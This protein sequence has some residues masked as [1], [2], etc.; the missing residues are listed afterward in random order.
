MRTQ[1]RALERVGSF[2][3]LGF[4]F[5]RREVDLPGL[6]LALHG[7]QLLHYVFLRELTGLQMA[8]ALFARV[9]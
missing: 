1:L 7:R 4:A 2:R 3:L 9:C 6:L 8:R 5:P